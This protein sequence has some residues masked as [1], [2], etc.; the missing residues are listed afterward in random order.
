[1]SVDKKQTTLT[2]CTRGVAEPITK[3]AI[4]PKTTFVLQ[5]DNITGIETVTFENGEKLTIKNWG[6]EYYV[7]TFCFETS[8][9][10][11]DTTNLNYWFKSAGTLMTEIL[12]GLEAPIDI[13]K[14]INNLIIHVDNDKVNNFKNL[15]LGEEINF[16]GDDIRSFV[17]VNR[18]EKLTDKK[19]AIEI[20]FATG[21]L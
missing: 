10:K 2:K 20:T 16:G 7:L 3:K 17:S 21:P 5:P 18:I 9:F 6:C 4:Y 13:K 14:G 1:M 12:G 11:Q 8:R 19:Y 15:K